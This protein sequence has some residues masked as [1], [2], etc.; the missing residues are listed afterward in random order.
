MRSTAWLLGLLVLAALVSGV[1]NLVSGSGSMAAGAAMHA[2]QGGILAAALGAIAIGPE[3]RWNTIRALFIT[4][5]RRYDILNAK[6]GVVAGLL[7]A[8]SLVA[9]LLGGGLS[10]FSD[11][12]GSVLD[13]LDL[14]ARAALVLIGWAILGFA[15]AGLARST[16]VGIAVPLVVAF[17]VE[18]IIVQTLKSEALASVLPFYS[19][20][21]AVTADVPTG[22]A[23]EHLAVFGVWVLLALGLSLAVL[24]RRDA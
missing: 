9:S 12:G 22:E 16:I 7:V 3:F 20:G 1:Q 21:R 4:F 23:Y 14:S 15:L 2:A 8:T 17:L 5:P 24:G 13:W 19:A 11:S 10:A 6:L 18:T